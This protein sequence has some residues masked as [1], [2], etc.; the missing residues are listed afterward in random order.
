MTRAVR[1][2]SADFKAKAA[3]EAIRCETALAALV[4][5]YG[6]ARRSGIWRWTAISAP[7]SSDGAPGG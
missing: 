2:S 3:L 1:R 4:I 7:I 6:G 5:T